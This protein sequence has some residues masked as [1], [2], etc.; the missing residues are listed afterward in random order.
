MYSTKTQ[1]KFI[2]L[3]AEGLSLAH[4]ADLTR[5]TKLRDTLETELSGRPLADLPI[6]KLFLLSAKLR[7]QIL[8]AYNHGNSSKSKLLPSPTASPAPNATAED[9]TISA[10]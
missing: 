1:R 7:T 2:Q 3:R 9:S 6:E 5:L 10:S 8:A 4:H